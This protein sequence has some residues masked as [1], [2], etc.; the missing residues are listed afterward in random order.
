MTAQLFTA[1]HCLHV[2][3]PDEKKNNVGSIRLFLKQH[4][5][6]HMAKHSLHFMYRCSFAPHPKL[7]GDC[8]YLALFSLNTSPL[9]AVQKSPQCTQSVVLSKW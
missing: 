7:G 6:H 1:F 3:T 5:G 8:Q 2:C 4:R 9:A